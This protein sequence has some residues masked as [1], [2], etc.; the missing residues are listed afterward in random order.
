MSE[1]APELQRIDDDERATR[2]ADPAYLTPDYVGTR[3]RA[4]RRP[5]LLLPQTLSELTGPAF[6]HDDVREGDS[7]L[8]SAAR[9]ASRSASASSSAAA[10]SARTDGPSATR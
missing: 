4:P 6:G 7:D 8:T 9:R 1:P 5:L 2:D 3:L 10:C